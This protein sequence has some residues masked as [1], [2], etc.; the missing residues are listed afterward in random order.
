VDAEFLVPDIF[1]RTHAALAKLG[2]GAPSAWRERL[3][4]IKSWISEQEWDARTGLPS[5]LQGSREREMP[6][7]EGQ[8]AIDM[9]TSFDEFARAP[10][11]DGLLGLAGWI[12]F[13]GLGAEA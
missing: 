2:D 5:V 7:L 12:E 6:R 10:S 1:G 4:K 8:M 13:F 3:E 9:R 11:L